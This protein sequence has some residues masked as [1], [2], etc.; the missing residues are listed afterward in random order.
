MEDSLKK[1]YAIKLL[2]S[3]ISGLMNG[4]LLALVPK[5][6]GPIAYGQFVYLQDFF[7]KFIGFLD[8]GTSTAFFTK[9]SAK[10]SRKELLSFYFLYAG[11]LFL[12]LYVVILGVVKLGY[13]TQLLPE[14]PSHFIFFGL[15]FGFL[16]WLTQIFVKISDAYALTS[17]V[18][19]VK[20]LHK[21]F[22]VVLLVF[23]VSM[24]SFDLEKYF[25]FHYIALGTFLGV[26]GWLFYHKKIVGSEL[27][28]FKSL[29]LKDLIQEF[30]SYCHPLFLYSIMGLGAGFFDIWLLQKV[31]G[32]EQ[33][34]F[35]GLSYG[36]AAMCFVF[37]GAMTPIITREFAKSFE[38]RD[39]QT[40]AKLFSR[41]I[42]MLYAIAAYFSLFILVQSE[43]VLE[44]FA[45]AKF[46]E[47]SVVLMVMALYPI[48]QTYGQLSGSVFYATGQTKLYRN[49]G[50]FSM[51]IGVLI[52]FILIYLFD[53]GAL[54]LA[55]KM[56]V[57]QFIGV[58][59]QLYFN[60]KFLN[61]SLKPFL[62]HQLYSVVFFT[63][64]AF[65]AGSIVKLDSPLG[66]FLLSGVFYTLLVIIFTYFVP[67]VFAS[68]KEEI[69]Y[70]V[71]TIAQKVKG[72]V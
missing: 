37:T 47:A 59:L 70:Y 48:H 24:S 44:I 22:S 69:N 60:V 50:I 56:V 45:D 15:F 43:N 58:N 19:L 62:F 68:K 27:F 51:S 13:N 54:G 30:F 18:E 34:G 42:P 52:S 36:I 64:L 65:S 1:R 11:L 23:F 28:S 31:A 40:M 4:V 35:Y 32:S 7:M 61:I 63:V 20:I 12:L 5:E 33:T 38:Q 2:A 67:Q 6:L 66:E 41:Y 3:V 16:T 25:Y 72:K 10:Q 49:I 57:I 55:L 71:H 9:L 21:I 17:S 46:Q 14:I 39:M 53:L 29:A 8:M 26:V